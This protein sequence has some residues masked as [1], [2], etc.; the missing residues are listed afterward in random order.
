M[1]T[2]VEMPKLSDTM[3]SGTLVS[4]KKNEGETVEP[5]EVIAEVESDKA[6][7]ELEAYER[8]ILRKIVAHVGE[9]V[10]IGKPIAIVSES[11]QENIEELLAGLDQGAKPA[12]AAEAAPPR[13]PPQA[14]AEPPATAMASASPSAPTRDEGR[15][16]VS[17][18]AARLAQELGLDLARIKGSGPGGRIVKRD[19]EQAKAAGITAMRPMGLIPSAPTPGMEHPELEYEDI[20][21]SQMR[22]IIAQR[23]TESM[24]QI[25]HYYV[26]IEIDMRQAIQ[27]REQLNT[28]EGV[29]ISLNDFILKAAALALEKH[30]LVNASFI[31]ASIRI[32]HRIDI[33]LAVA[34]AEGL[35]TPVIRQA[36]KKGLLEISRESRELAERA[37]GKRLRPE[38]YAGS[39]FTVSNLG[40]LGVKQFTAVINPPEAAILAVGATRETPVVEN[41]QLTVGRR[42]DVTMSS[43]HRV[44][45]G[46]QSA[47][48]LKDFKYFLENPITFAL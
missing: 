18:L 9:S 29:K 10:P 40:M 3:D 6:T 4:W 33:G 14:E 38:E 16:A 35:I 44:I 34:M 24:S 39:T 7:M 30:P 2:I 32:Y 37:R 26:T 22:K 41:G 13:R 20:P 43:D 28:L 12:P 31:G 21:N 46:A 36:N 17:P 15:M 19:I 48:F 11:P 47:R 42:M 45:D 8:G 5:G 27:L 23:L 1:A 25:P